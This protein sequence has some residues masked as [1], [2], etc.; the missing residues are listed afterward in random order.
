MVTNHFLHYITL[1][2]QN[3]YFSKH[4]VNF[5]HPKIDNPAKQWY[6]TNI[7]IYQAHQ[8][9]PCRILNLQSLKGEKS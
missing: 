7:R 6:N 8:E 3:Q 5:I 4:N 2:Y 9:K 1:Q